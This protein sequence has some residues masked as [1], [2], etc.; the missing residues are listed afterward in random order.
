MSQMTMLRAKSYLKESSRIAELVDAEE[1]QRLAIALDIL[2]TL[3]GRLFLIGIGGSAANCCHAVNDFRKLCNIYAQ[4]PCDNVA[5]LTARANDEGW[6]RIFVD[7]L[8]MSR[9]GKRDALFVLSVG[10]G[11]PE[12]SLPIVRAVEYANDYD[13]PVYGI[14]G[15][16]GGYT[17]KHGDGVII[18]PTLSP[19]LVTAHT[20]AFQSVILHYLVSALQTRPTKW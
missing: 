11:T 12:V 7:W 14:V 6:D 2:R 3:G 4:T 10:G 18:I 19:E 17:A 13:M 1:V 16:D 9:A 20:E 15:R 8:F 5:E